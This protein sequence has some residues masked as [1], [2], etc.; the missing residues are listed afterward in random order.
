MKKWFGIL[1]VFLGFWFCVLPVRADVIWEPQDSFYEKHTSEC[2]Y[3]GRTYT[4]NGPEGE[5]ILYESPVSSRKVA[6]WKNGYKVY[7][8]FSYEDQNGTLWGVCEDGNKSGWMPMEYMD[9]VYDNISFAQEYA[10]EIREQSGALDEKYLNQDI[11]VWNYPAS[12]S[13]YS[14]KITDHL[15]EYHRTY[16]DSQ[17]HLWGNVG[18]YYGNKDFWMCL[19]MPDAEPEALY[20]DA[21]P[22]IGR[23]Q[24]EEKDFTG[25]RITPEGGQDHTIV[26]AVGMVLAVVLLTAGLLFALKK[27]GVSNAADSRE[28][29]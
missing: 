2:K 13:R 3:V 20:P 7:I 11:Y 15:P 24:P 14:M 18:Y 16:T 8:Q 21:A 22:E 4:A 12:S 26:L 23:S 9:V 25:G 29:L 10:A 19:D 27:K 17:G 6:V 5:V 28:H 1:G